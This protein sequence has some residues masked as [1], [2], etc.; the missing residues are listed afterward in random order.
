MSRQAQHH[1]YLQDLRAD[2]ACEFLLNNT[3]FVNWYRAP[4]SR[5]LAILGDMGS[6]KTVAMTFLVDELSRR[7]EYQLPQPKIC[8]YYCRGDETGKAIYIFSALILSL[9]E[10]LPG[11]KKPFFEWYKQAQVSGFFDPATNTK[12]LE[13]FLQKLLDAIDRPVFI[14]IDGLD[15]CNRASRNCLLK[16]LKTLSQRVMGLKTILSF[17]PQEEILG[18]LDGVARIHLGSDA[19]RDG[20]IV[21]KTV[22]RQLFYLSTDVKAFVTERL[23]RLAQGSAIWSKMVVELIEVR[24]I[25]AINPMRFFFE[26]IPLPRQLSKLY[27][28]IFS[29]CTAKDPENQEI[30]ST[31]LGLLAI[32]H[33]PLSIL[34]LAWAVTFGATQHVTSVDALAKL[35]DPQRI[36]SLIHPF[37]AC[38][39][40]SNLRKCQVQLTHQSVKE[41]IT[42]EWTPN[43]PDRQGSALTETDNMLLDRRV[44]SLEAFILDI[45]IRYLLL[46]DI[47]NRDL[48]SEEQMAI[49]ELPQEVDLFNDDEE[50]VEYDPYCTWESWE[51]KMIR[52][53]PTNRGFGEFFVYA[54][55]HWLEHFGAT[56][57]EHLPGL[58]S[59]EKLCQADSTRLRNWTQQN[60]RPG[61]AIMPRFQFDSSLYDPLSI[62]SLYGSEATLRHMLG[63]SDFEKDTFLREPA[64]K[65]ADQILDWGD[66][67]RLKIL[68]LDEKLGHQ[69]QNL[70]FFRLLI[71]K[72][73]NHRGNFELAFDLVDY[74]SDILVHAQ[75][76]N[77]LLCVAASEGCMPIIRRL[78]TSAQHKPALKNELLREF[79]CEAQWSRS[80]E[81]MHQSIGEAVLGNHVDVV[82]YLL[83]END[84][85]AHLRYRN[86]RGENVLHLASRLCNP[87]MFQLLVPR[88]QEGI[89]QADNQGDT[90]LERIIMSSSTSLDR[91]ES[92][93]ILLVQSG[94]DWNSH[95][96]DG[97]QDPL[98]AAVQLGDLDMCRLFHS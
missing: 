88:F 94:T 66:V 44:E 11:L 93:K 26:E 1:A 51:E 63:N 91:Y 65:A 69:L 13:E 89:H 15:D 45:C 37:I 47:G 38:V 6:G 24:G 68:F 46:D 28:T 4:N 78:I 84:I 87:D 43:K 96:S 29:R 32:T 48:F 85:E 16:L 98:W 10:Q 36:M 75:W 18:Q 52:F 83:E 33:R 8:Y 95:F 50:S 62:T 61:C 74:V 64:M 41:F 27:A 22:E 60:C 2:R 71:K 12:K 80:G 31:A 81:P 19:Q 67:P 42:R 34:E 17:R 39:D 56:A 58:A 30:A 40:F 21:E 86:S 25:R 79:Q 92:A 5:Q 49:A 35:V 90:A 59:I 14:I 57:V 3:D 7:N 72:W 77:E 9:L 73:P 20:I 82:R 70:N 53:D 76:G 23:S 97:Q 55:C 54:S